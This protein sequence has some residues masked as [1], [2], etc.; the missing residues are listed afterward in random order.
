MIREADKHFTSTTVLADLGSRSEGIVQIKRVI[1]I[2]GVVQIERVIQIYR[3]HSDLGGGSFR[4]RGSFRLCL[5]DSGGCS[6]G[7]CLSDL[8][9]PLDFAEM[10]V[11]LQSFRIF[12]SVYGQIV[13]KSFE[14]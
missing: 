11:I 1:Q 14:I 10:F 13:R 5:S 8:V 4:F 6:D 3:D 7:G 2:E 9:G 12:C